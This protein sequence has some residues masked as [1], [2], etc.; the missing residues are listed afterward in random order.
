MVFLRIPWFFLGRM[1]V[2]KWMI[3][4]FIVAFVILEMQI[5]QMTNVTTHDDHNEYAGNLPSSNILRDRG[6]F[7][8]NYESDSSTRGKARLQ[9]EDDHII[10][11]YNRVPKTG[12]TSFMGVLY[13]LC[14]PNRF[15][16]LHLNVSRNS[17]VMS[18]SDQIRFARNITTWKQ[19]MP[20]VYHGHLAY[21]DFQRLGVY[22]SPLFINMIRKPLDRLVSYYYFLRFGDDFRPYLRRTRQ[23]DKETFDECVQNGNPDCRP[24]RLWLQIPYFCGHAPQCWS[25][26]N[27]WA[28]EQAKRNLVEKYL[29]VGITEEMGNFVAVLEVVLPRIFKGAT[30]LFN[31]GGKSHLRKT[32]SK[33]PLESSTIEYFEQSKIW[34]MENDFYEFANKVFQDAKKR[35]LIMKDGILEPVKKQ[36]FYEK[37]R[38]K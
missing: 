38:P 32:A 31:E 28:L 17:H 2:N 1:I 7:E 3:V 16:A 35:A 4:A 29:L 6:Q 22:Q 14:R 19:V 5:L 34:K 30:K 13:A 36:F 15:H 27:K 8:N 20:A 18:L 21:M 25:P 37:I 23:G 10:I 11:F 24:E 9:T 26:G 12:S 33:K